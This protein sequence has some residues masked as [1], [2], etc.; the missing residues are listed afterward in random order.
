VPDAPPPRIARR[1][2]FWLRKGSLARALELGRQ[3]KIV[4]A[5]DPEV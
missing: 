2:V 5:V 3:R 1:D 4:L